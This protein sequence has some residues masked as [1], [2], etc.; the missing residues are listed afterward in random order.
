MKS[1]ISLTLS[2][3][4]LLTL[5]GLLLLLGFLFYLMLSKSRESILSASNRLRHEVGTRV[6]AQ[7]VAFRDQA[8]G[9]VGNIEREFQNDLVHTTDR[10]GLEAALF[11]QVLNNADI[12][13]VSFTHGDEI[14]IDH[15]DLQIAPTNRWELSVYRDDSGR[16]IKRRVIH[17]GTGGEDPTSRQTFTTPTS[18]GN[19]N[20]AIWSDLHYSELSMSQVEV[21]VQK[22]I[23]DGDK[24]FLG[25]VRVGLLMSQLKSIVQRGSHDN[26]NDPSTC[27]LCDSDGRLITP[28]GEQ[29]KI[30]EFGNDLRI[31]PVNLPPEIEAELQQDVLHHIQYENE[32]AT[33]MA[34]GKRYLVSYL[35]L[36]KTQDWVL[37]VSASEDSYLHDLI[38]ARN[39]LLKYAAIVMAMI[40]VGGIIT[41][42]AVQRGLARVVSETAMMRRFEFAPSESAARFRD[43]QRV[44]E[45]LEQAK[46]AVR[47]MGKYVPLDLV[48]ELYQMNREPQLG[49]ETRDL[50]I[51]FTDIQGFTTL[52]ETLSPDRLAMAL[53]EYL[54]AVAGALHDHEGTID[55]YIGDSVMA[56]W[57]APKLCEDHPIK[58]CAAALACMRAADAVARTAAWKGLP[59]PV[60]RCGIHHDKVML[61]HFGSP[62]RMS[63]TCMG[64]GVNLASRLESLNKQYG[65]TVLVSQ[66]IYDVAKD[67]FNFRMLDRVAVRGKTQSINVYELRMERSGAIDQYEA[68]LHMYWRRDFSGAMEILKNQTDDPPSK[69][70]IER[71]RMF[72]RIAPPPEWDGVFVAMMK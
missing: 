14:G 48:R 5:V 23:F 64:D 56:I 3:V 58:A 15:G 31:K 8:E 38:A 18:D 20:R 32:D 44:L 60:T 16:I 70:L 35:P 42:R 49:G 28:V 6:S 71:C 36:K 26:P 51:L 50:T 7:V 11:T 22:S 68:A 62:D 33:V 66:A 1:R 13:D 47:A 52:S 12:G 30:A 63:Y 55:K 43:I 65:T 59:P 17:D 39:E 25:V 27:F 29:D 9:V 57:N 67:K 69:V 45:S 46:T 41:V 72:L 19:F 10:D 2:Q 24:K 34:D 40:L 53:G 21:S 4:F 61:G 37:A 54:Q